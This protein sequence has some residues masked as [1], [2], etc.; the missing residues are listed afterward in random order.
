MPS[1]DKTPDASTATIAATPEAV[2]FNKTANRLSMWL[3][4]A[5]PAIALLPPRKLD[6]YTYGLGAMTLLSADHLLRWRGGRS[7]IQYAG[8]ALGADTR[9][10]MTPEEYAAMERR[11][12]EAAAN[13]TSI[14]GLP[15]EKARAV[16]EALREQKRKKK[17]E[18][19]LTKV[20]M[21]GE[22][23]GWQE[24]RLRE[25]REAIA[26]GEGYGD[27]IKKYLDEAWPWSKKEKD[28]AA[29]DVDKGKEE[30][31]N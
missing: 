14:D 31:K 17:E 19:M 5:C 24:K 16:Q 15:T 8:R 2:G 12:A 7:G 29:E 22:E 13:A 4:F 9:V 11:R 6:I 3:L 30:G 25:E 23:E 27:L 10:A 20:W 26:R 21:G 1:P 28:G 18:G